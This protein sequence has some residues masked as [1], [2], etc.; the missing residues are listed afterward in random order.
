MPSDG[1]T[2]VI[3]RILERRAYKPPAHE[4]TTAALAVMMRILQPPKV[5]IA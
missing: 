4:G 3:Q 5:L 1:H 2:T